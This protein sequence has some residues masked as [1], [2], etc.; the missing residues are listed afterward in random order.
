[1]NSS[2][3]PSPTSFA[4]PPPG[5][6]R[7]SPSTQLSPRSTK[8]HRPAAPH[9]LTCPQLPHQSFNP[10]PFHPYPLSNSHFQT[11]VAHFYPPPPPVSYTRICLPSDDAQATLYVDIAFGDTLAPDAEA[12]EKNWTTVP[13]HS[14]KGLFEH[15]PESPPVAVVLHGL[16]SNARS[17]VSRRIASA[18][19]AIGLKVIILNYR[20]C[21]EDEEI[22]TTL[23]LY[24]AGFTEDIETVLRAVKQAAIESGRR[25]PPV[26]LCGFSLGANVACQFLGKWREEAQTLFN[27]VAGAVACVPFDPTACQRE[28]DGGWKGAIYSRRL[29][30]TMQRKFRLAVEDG[31]DLG[32][33][34]IGEIE[35]AD[36][37]GKIDSAYIAPM[38]G[39]RDK[40]DYYQ[41]VRRNKCF[42]FTRDSLAC[43]KVW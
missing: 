32:R 11:V 24:H 3:T 30:R 41:K 40:E 27:V 2:H 12:V 31:V 33:C 43:W 37:V 20:S 25:P 29:V 15:L 7:P 5:L 22:P 23:K 26:Y 21:A 34:E 1:M 4:P 36:R 35:L 16:E 9:M 18:L 6:K 10:K 8:R 17:R 42:P 13:S 28:L 14:K 19:G 39:F 38:F